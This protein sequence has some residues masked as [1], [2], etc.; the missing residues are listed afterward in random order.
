MRKST[1]VETRWPIFAGS[2][3]ISQPIYELLPLALSAN[4]VDIMS[5]TLSETE[6]NTQEFGTFP[7]V[8][9]QLFE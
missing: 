1:G 3:H 6:Q 9:A 8:I 2:S 4:I 7:V 5:Q